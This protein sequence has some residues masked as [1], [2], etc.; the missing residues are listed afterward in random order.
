MQFKV[1]KKKPNRRK[2]TTLKSSKELQ[3]IALHVIADE[4]KAIEGLEKHI[5]NS[6]S[7]AVE[8][9]F[10]AQGRVIVTGIGK[11]ANIA[12]KIVSTLNSTGT[13]ALF[14]HAADAIHGDLGMIQQGDVVICISKS[15]NTPEIKV[16]IPLVRNFGNRL[17][18][19][20]GTSGM[21]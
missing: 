21:H 18:A 3:E 1:S 12:A 7:E 8:T 6:F 9:I 19:I 17:I 4:K 16:L 13:P 15:G 10:S 14:M 5:G 11:S 20:V 2:K